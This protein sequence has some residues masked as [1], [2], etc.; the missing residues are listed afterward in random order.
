[1]FNREALQKYIEEQGFKQKAIAAKSGIDDTAFSK[2]LSG[3][4]KCEVNEYIAICK[5]LGVKPNKFIEE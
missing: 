1:M 4:R 5:A 3:N 2:I